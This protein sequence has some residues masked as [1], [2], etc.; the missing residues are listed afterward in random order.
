M[1]VLVIDAGGMALDFCLRA[2]AAGHS[3]RWYL[4]RLKNGDESKIGNGF[5]A[6]V[7]D[8]RKHVDW[9]DLIFLTDNTYYLDELDAIRAKGKPV[10]GPTKAGA[11]L[12]LDRE[13][14]QK[15][16]ADAGIETLPFQEFSSYDKAEAFVRK[17]GKRFVSKPSG[18]ADKALSYLSK[19][20]ADMVMMLRR[21][22]ALGKGK[23]PFILQ[24][25]K[26]GV[27][28]AVG[29]WIGPSGWSRWW[30]EN[31]EHK[32]LMSGDM[33]PN[34]GEMGTLAKYTKQSAVAK[35][36]LIPLE[37]HLVELGVTGY[38]DV[39]AICDDEGQLWPLEFT[40]RPG[41]PTF[42]LQMSMHEGDPCE[43]M[44][45]LCEGRDTLKAS[46]AHCAGILMAIPDFPY[47]RQT[48]REVA[49]FPIYG[50]DD[51]DL[52]NVHFAEV[53]REVAPAMQDDKI[54][55]IEMPVSAGDYILIATG[56]GDSVSES[57]ETSYATLDALSM[58]YSPFWRID[59]GQRLKKQL[60]ELQALGLCKSWRF[61]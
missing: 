35:E 30:C 43:W 26:E 12:E 11:E 60:P 51:I 54:V 28:V 59:I 22:K 31:F 44:L 1:K 61:K 53:M 50:L 41:W 58:P 5:F 19:N 18:D 25:F 10:F 14:G 13:L 15:A 17:E 45:A 56:L 52:S 32:K 48:K 42:N 4:K 39:A 23:P 29:G 34:T 38:V 55:E 40:V 57:C 49:G 37:Q 8:W 46:E 16:F 27:E 2:E 47:S 33:G 24:E 21:W 36:L 7:D 6:K 20:P 9:A 3:V